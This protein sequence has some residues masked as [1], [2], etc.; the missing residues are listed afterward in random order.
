[1]SRE[2]AKADPSDRLMDNWAV[3][4]LI[5][6]AT[7]KSDKKAKDESSESYATSP[8][9]WPGRARARLSECSPRPRQRLGS[10]SVSMK[11]TMRPEWPEAA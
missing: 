4:K 10:P 8:P 5:D 2:I 6:C 1:V 11:R 9:S 7:G 3:T